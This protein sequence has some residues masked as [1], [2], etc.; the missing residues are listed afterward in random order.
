LIFRE[1]T[2]FVRS[3]LSRRKAST[4][5][6]RT[7]I[8]NIWHRRTRVVRSGSTGEELLLLL[9][10]NLTTKPEVGVVSHDCV[11]HLLIKQ[12]IHHACSNR[13]WLAQDD[14]LSD[15]FAVVKFAIHSS[16]VQDLNSLF[17]RA[18]HQ[19]PVVRLIDAMSRDS[20]DITSEGHTIAENAQVTSVDI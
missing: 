5:V 2:R 10:S 13:S 19:W 18:T 14:V 8:A 12:N 4:I 1:P 6:W 3:S 17:E 7:D 20:G 16:F 11:E 15:T 9:D